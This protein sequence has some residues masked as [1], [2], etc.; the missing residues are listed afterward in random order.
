MHEHN[1]QTARPGNPLPEEA[2]HS[3]TPER[4]GQRTPMRGGETDH[5]P[6]RAARS[7]EPLSRADR[8]VVTMLAA[9]LGGFVAIGGQLV[10]L[11][12]QIGE[13][14]T[15]MTREIGGLRTEMHSEFGKLSDRLTRVETRL[16]TV[17]TR[18]TTVETRLTTVE[19]R[20]TTVETR[21][22][23]AAHRCR[24][25]TLRCR[26][27]DPDPPR[28][29]ARRPESGGTL[30]AGYPRRAKASSPARGQVLRST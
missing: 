26:S 8:I 11:Q 10:G 3:Y 27:R 4:D 21:C 22:R 19:T 7:R 14:R 28:A 30:S 5:A 29:G 25:P 9:M 18:L 16:T 23:N 24:N 2:A 15:D 1:V 17:E 13:V 6:G 20:L 12:R